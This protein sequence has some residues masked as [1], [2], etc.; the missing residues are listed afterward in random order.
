MLRKYRQNNF[1]S[2]S[3]GI[4]WEKKHFSTNNNF[5]PQQQQK[6]RRDKAMKN[7]GKSEIS[8]GMNNFLKR[9]NLLSAI[10]LRSQQKKST[11]NSA[12]WHFLFT[13]PAIASILAWIGCCKFHAQF[14]FL[15]TSKWWTSK[16]V[17]KKKDAKWFK[18]QKDRR[19][20]LYNFA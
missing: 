18:Y 4:C 20:Q 8:M 17:S 11:K 6:N 12:W 1:F 7:S 3:L 16:R 5:Q 19:A 2:L 14:F 13:L 10:T 15:C 9:C